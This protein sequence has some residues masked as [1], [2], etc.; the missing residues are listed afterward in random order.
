MEPSQSLRIIETSL[1]LIVREK[2][3]S[4]QTA[5]G[6][7]SIAALEGK[8]GEE[9]RR[10]DGAVVSTDLLDYTATYELTKLILKNWDAGFHSVFDDK[11][12]TESF[13]AILEDVRNTI[14]HNR[15]LLAF[16][17]DLLTGIAGML[18][19]QVAIAR[20]SSN[21]SMNY[22]P[23]IETVTDNFGNGP[24]SLREALAGNLPD[25]TRLEVGDELVFEGSAS[26]I[27]GQEAIWKVFLT[28]FSEPLGSY[29]VRP[30]NARGN[31]VT[32][33]L[34]ITEDDIGET[35]KVRVLLTTEARYHRHPVS[36]NLEAHDDSREFLYAVNPP[37]A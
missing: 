30:V 16:E 19:N 37:H 18:R 14:A 34:P 35:M 13:F 23:L 32:L 7:P 29:Q 17:R 11:K 6:A 15:D 25:T 26:A 12:R 3:P 4:W 33:R 27:E 20:S 9:S 28:P 2:L 10:R 5:P 1:R 36:Y 21:R 8:Q 24:Y 31:E 22:Y